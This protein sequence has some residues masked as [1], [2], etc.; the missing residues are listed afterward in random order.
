[1]RSRLL[2]ERSEW[3]RLGRGKTLEF[4]ATDDEVRQW[5]MH[6]PAEF[7][8]YKLIG[9][10]LVEVS[11]RRFVPQQWEFELSDFPGC[12]QGPREM[13]WEFGIWSAKLS[14]KPATTVDRSAKSPPHNLVLLQHGGFLKLPWLD[15]K[16]SQKDVRRR[17]ESSIGI[18]DRIINDKTGEVVVFKE[19]LEIFNSLR[20][21]IEKK[22]CFA[23][24][25]SFRDGT[26]LETTQYRWTE[27]AVRL[28][29]SGFPFTYRP[30]RRLRD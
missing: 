30:G 22:L 1:M 6:L 9:Y 7:R 24:I 8:P 4:F 20:K 11:K 18:V 27:A 28:Y 19:Y 13:R 26:E 14:P 5:L 17:V 10:D 3:R 25:Q 16:L 2:S 29:E 12:M 15:L 23:S 21:E